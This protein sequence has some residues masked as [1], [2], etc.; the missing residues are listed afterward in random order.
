MANAEVP[1]YFSHD[2]KRFV[3]FEQDAV[4][5]LK[6]KKVEDSKI[7]FKI[8]QTASKFDQAMKSKQFERYKVVEDVFVP[9]FDS[10]LKNVKGQPYIYFLSKDHLCALNTDEVEQITKIEPQKS[11]SGH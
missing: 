10:I 4:P 5:C 11:L 1:V 7:K 9:E 2:F 8:Y 6:T 3:T